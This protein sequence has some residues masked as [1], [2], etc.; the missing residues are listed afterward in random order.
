MGVTVLACAITQIDPNA[1]GSGIPEM[2]S[3]LTGFLSFPSLDLFSYL[4][5]YSQLVSPSRNLP[6]IGTRLPKYL[7]GWVFIAK[8]FG[9]MVAMGAGLFLGTEGPFVHMSSILAQ[10]MINMRFFRSLMDNPALMH[11]ILSAAVTAGVAASLA[12]P[13]GGLMF[14]IE[15]SS[16]YWPTR[17]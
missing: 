1:I 12:S 7:S 11:Q 6:F 3:L 14:S 10:K 8:Y 13:I 17:R 4:I 15:V 16:N 5:D 2:K 9:L